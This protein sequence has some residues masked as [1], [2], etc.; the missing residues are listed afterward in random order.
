M[1]NT[2]AGINKL[3]DPT[4]IIGE[5]FQVMIES[6]SEY[7]G[8]YIVSRRKYLQSLIPEEVSLLEF[9]TP[10]GRVTGTTPFGVF[11]E[12]NDCLTGMIHKANVVEEWQN[13]IS[14]IK[15]GQEIEFYIKEIIKNKIILTQVLRETLWDTKNGQ[16]IEGRVKDVKQFGA[17]IILDNET[18]D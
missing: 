13:R 18:I 1:P 6:F 14:E 4:S 3:Y 2:L 17:L 10:Y 12:F 7:E 11:V 8:T 9:N 5:T 15:P 16:V